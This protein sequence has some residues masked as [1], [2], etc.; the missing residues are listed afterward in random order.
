[1]S[2]NES[3]YSRVHIQALSY[4]PPLPLSG[5]RVGQH[6]FLDPFRNKTRPFH[7]GRQSQI[8]RQPK[9]ILGRSAKSDITASAMKHVAD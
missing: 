6:L 4:F 7:P 1:M 8:V 3:H 9:R 5:D 2:T